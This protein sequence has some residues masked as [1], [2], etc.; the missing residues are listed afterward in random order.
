VPDLVQLAKR[1][2]FAIGLSATWPNAR[3][4]HQSTLFDVLLRANTRVRA[5]VDAGGAHLTAAPGIEVVG[6]GPLPDLAVQHASYRFDR[7]RFDVDVGGF[8]AGPLV[9]G[10]VE[11]FLNAKVQ[12]SLPAT[13]RRQGYSPQRD[14][15]LAR[16]TRELAAALDLGGGAR[17]STNGLPAELRAARDLTVFVELVVAEDVAL[18][19]PDLDGMEVFVARGTILHAHLRTHGN[20]DTPVLDALEVRAESKGVVIRSTAAGPLAA[21]EALEVTSLI[22]RPPIGTDGATLGPSTPAF[23]FEYELLV[24]KLIDGAVRLATLA[25][26][27]GGHYMPSEPPEIRLRSFRENVDRMLHD[28]LS[29]LFEGLLSQIDGVVPGISVRRLLQP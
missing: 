22:V 25:T 26:F 8:L 20:L 2:V 6:A 28:G 24:E 18:A 12:P 16:T 3:R 17:P 13:I 4:L 15:D 11:A 10:V 21:L 19:V 14:A 29:A 1:S 5:R 23:S 7:A 27:L 9:E